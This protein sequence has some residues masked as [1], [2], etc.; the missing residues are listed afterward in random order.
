VSLAEASEHAAIAMAAAARRARVLRM[1]VSPECLS[2]PAPDIV[3]G[4]ECGGRIPETPWR[5][6]VGIT[7]FFARSTGKF[8]RANGRGCDLARGA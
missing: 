5:H 2:S 7:R 4:V 1:R 6:S 8:V 3:S